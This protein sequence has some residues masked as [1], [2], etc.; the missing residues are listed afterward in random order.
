MAILDNNT[1]NS[2]QVEDHVVVKNRWVGTGV[3]LTM[4]ELDDFTEGG[5]GCGLKE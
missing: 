5:K 4:P 3:A 1:V 2:I